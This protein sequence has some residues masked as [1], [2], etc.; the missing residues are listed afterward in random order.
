M[1]ASSTVRH[2]VAV[3]QGSQ[4]SQVFCPTRYTSAF[5]CHPSLP[6]DSSCVPGRAGNLSGI[7]IPWFTLNIFIQTSLK[8]RR[9][10]TTTASVS[11]WDAWGMA[12]HKLGERRGWRL[13]VHIVRNDQGVLWDSGVKVIIYT[14]VYF[15]P[16]VSDTAC[17]MFWLVA[18]PST[19]RFWIIMNS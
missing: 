18:F 17:R 10:C 11:A 4:S 13:M 8:W 5:T 6:W 12:L 16:H 2:A 3:R 1:H 9:W 19:P 7:L 15:V 14:L